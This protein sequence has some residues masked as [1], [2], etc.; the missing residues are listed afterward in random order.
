MHDTARLFLC[1]RCGKHVHIC[2]RCDRGQIYCADGCGSRA[3]RES[4]RE[5]GRRYQSSLRGRLAHVQR[6]LRF[7]A[8]RKNVTHQG[9]PAAAPDWKCGRPPVK[10]AQASRRLRRR[11]LLRRLPLGIFT[12]VVTQVGSGCAGV[13]FVA[14][15]FALVDFEGSDCRSCV[16]SACSRYCN[17]YTQTDKEGSKTAW[18][19]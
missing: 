9:S 13:R 4:L 16:V 2:T 14:V 10:R 7:R 19:N 6:S 3:R 12:F 11:L 8:R 1:A 18:D 5:A 17:R 15:L